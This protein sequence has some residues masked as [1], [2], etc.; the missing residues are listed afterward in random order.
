LPR[1]Y[2]WTGGLA[3]AIF[4]PLAATLTERAVRRM[5]GGWK[6]PQ[7]WTYVAAILTPVHR[8]TL[9]DWGGIGPALVHFAPL[10]MSEA[11]RLWKTAARHRERPA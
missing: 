6:G 7:R 5:G 9:H 10:G 8:E 2:I 4:V 3:V 11:F 1:R